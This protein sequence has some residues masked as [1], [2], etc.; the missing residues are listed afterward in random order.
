[1]CF[2][3][4]RQ[5]RKLRALLQRTSILGFLRASTPAAD[6][7][8]YER[9][10]PATA[11]APTYEEIKTPVGRTNY[12]R[13]NSDNPYELERAVSERE[14]PAAA[15]A[16]AASVPVVKPAPDKSSVYSNTTTLVDNALYGVHQ[17][18]V[19]SSHAV[20]VDDDVI[21]NDREG[22]GQ[23]Q[24]NSGFTT[25]ECTLIDNDLYR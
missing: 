19:T 12:D 6:E 10:T 21:N 17:P 18:P 22:R 5:R 11:T 13:A 4:E 23:G 14:R 24:Q 16:P 15:A 2:V 20:G 25:Y 1:M 3:Y 8:K 9:S 7:P